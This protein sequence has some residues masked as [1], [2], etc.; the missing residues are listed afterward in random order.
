M[1]N[2]T[3]PPWCSVFTLADLELFDF[4]SDLKNYYSDG[5]GYEITG[6]MTQPVFQELFTKIDEHISGMV[7]NSSVI[8]NSGHS[9]GL[10]P[11][12]TALRMFKDEDPLLA[13]DWPDK[14]DHKWHMATIAGFANNIGF[15]QLQC[16][17]GQENKIML[18]HNE[19]P[20]E[21]PAC[22]SWF[23]RWRIS[24]MPIKRLL[25]S[26]LRR[27]VLGKFQQQLKVLL[28]ILAMMMVEIM[29]EIMMMMMMM[30]MMMIMTMMMMTMMMKTVRK[31]ALKRVMKM[32]IDFQSLKSSY[33]NFNLPYYNAYYLIL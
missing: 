1:G 26:A 8:L 10:K 31:T 4:A 11:I 27:S 14:K 33:I 25:I 28:V 9:S 12:L 32:M 6:K 19:K 17:E 13:S 16:E 24:R 29:T 22:G 21:N 18:L 5:D 3:F 20:V 7:S 30:T 23:A 15:L 2:N